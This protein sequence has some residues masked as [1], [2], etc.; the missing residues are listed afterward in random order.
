MFLFY[1]QKKTME[2][3][4]KGSLSWLGTNC[5]DNSWVK[6]LH[7][8]PESAKY[9]PNKSSREVKSGHYVP[10]KPSPL[11]SPFLVAYS[12]PLAHTMGF[13][14]EA[15]KSEEFLQFFSGSGNEAFPTSWCTPYALSIYGQEM[16]QNCPFGTGNGYGDGRAISVGEITIENSENLPNHWEMQLKGAGTTPFCRGGDGRAVLRSSVR[17]FLV[18]EAMFHLNV[19][20]TRALS[21]V[22]SGTETVRRPWFSG[23]DAPPV[24]SAEDL[25]AQ[26]IHP[27]MLPLFLARMQDR[28]TSPDIMQKSTCAITCRV[29]PSFMRIGHI[30]LFGRRARKGGKL[31]REELELI[32]E[33]AIKRE[34][35]HIN[36][37]PRETGTEE[38]NQSDSSLAPLSVRAVDFL[39]EVSSRIALLT[40]DWLRVGFTQGNFNSDNCLVAGRTMDYGPFGFIEKFSPTWNMW[41]GGG[42]HYSFMN[43]PTAG[44]RNFESLVMAV[45]PLLGDDED[46]VIEKV[47]EI[48]N[49]HRSRAADFANDMWSKKLGL[50][51]TDWNFDKK[52]LLDNLFTLM[53]E[54]EADYT[55]FWRQLSHVVEIHLERDFENN[56]DVFLPL[57]DCFYKDLS[58][59]EKTAWIKWLKRHLA[60]CKSSVTRL[61]SEDNAS[62]SMAIASSMRRVSPKF[63]PREWMLVRAYMTAIEGDYDLLHELEKVFLAPYE[64][65]EDK[66]ARRYYRKAPKEVYCGVVGLG[67]T[68]FMT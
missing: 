10:V 48:S 65:G 43:Q 38:K 14:E 34:F 3:Q 18:S 8:D 27:Q 68:A 47:K 54:T 40:A 16:Y 42:E 2:P 4:D 13:S 59:R 36:Q 21:L 33:H 52:N 66:I 55:L 64:E 28:L 63:V 23:A 17:E 58:L 6:D 67:G 9:A 30:E 53:E 26:G 56:D 62:V 57:T 46:E 35:P 1:I 15:C 50:D 20:T 25:R 24:P 19:S 41:T 31:A 39:D 29:A 51:G 60:L 61:S 7:S 44:T 37:K 22:A 32:V 12:S 5:L 11:P 49:K 45:A